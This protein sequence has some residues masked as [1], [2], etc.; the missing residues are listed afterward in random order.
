MNIAILTGSNRLES[1]ST[2][3]CRYLQKQLEEIGCT[4]SFID[5]YKAPVPFF[6][7]DNRNPNDHNLIAMKQTILLADAVVLSTPD[8]HGGVSG[9][10]KNAL[11]HLGFEHFDSKAVLSVSS[12][13]GAV[14]VSPLQQLQVMVR[15]VHGINCPEW[16]SIGAENRVFD[17]EGAPI[18]IKIQE[19]IGKT[20][21]YFVKLA[22]QL[23]GPSV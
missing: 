8:Y 16:I 14:G 15:N 6:T 7:P 20:L 5:L 13:G 19:R 18:N 23:R 9:V 12:S 4:V 1:T 11:D 21:H 17:E 2:K 22:A 10:L 3:L